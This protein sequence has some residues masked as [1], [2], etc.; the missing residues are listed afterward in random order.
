LSLVE[1]DRS[2]IGEAARQLM[3]NV[4]R[5]LPGESEL[6]QQYRRKLAMLLF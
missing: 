5:V 3:V 4:F 1:L 2:G 6:V